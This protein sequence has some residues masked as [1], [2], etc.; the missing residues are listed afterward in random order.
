MG[1][2]AQRFVSQLCKHY[3]DS[4]R[5]CIFPLLR[6]FVSRPTTVNTVWIQVRAVAEIPDIRMHDLRHTV[7]SYAVLAGYPIPSTIV[8]SQVDIVN[9]SLYSRGGSHI[10]TAAQKIGQVIGDLLTDKTKTGQKVK[11]K[12]YQR[13][14]SVWASTLKRATVQEPSKTERKSQPML[15]AT[16]EQIRRFR[17]ELDFW[18]WA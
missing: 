18:E 11:E 16:D 13:K 7:A 12:S 1:Q 8:R 14:E 17:N 4:Q 15:S 5:D 3:E 6:D 10:G 2:S 9:A